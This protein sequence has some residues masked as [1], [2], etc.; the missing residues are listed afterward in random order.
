VTP[1]TPT[2]GTPS[3]LPPTVPTGGSSPG[4]SP[5][6]TNPTDGTGTILSPTFIV[7][8]FG[9]GGS[10]P[11]DA[12]WDAN[13]AVCF[14]IASSSNLFAGGPAFS[15]NALSLDVDTDLRVRSKNG[16]MVTP[17]LDKY[18]KFVRLYTLGCFDEARTELNSITV[19]RRLATE[20]L[21]QATMNNWYEDSSTCIG[22]DPKTCDYKNA[23]IVYYQNNGN[24]P[25]DESGIKERVREALSVIAQELESHPDVDDVA[26]DT[27][28]VAKAVSQNSD[29]GTDSNAGTIVGATAAGLALLLFL[30]LW[31]KRNKDSDEVSHLKF[32][33]DDETFVNEFEGKNGGLESDSDAEGRRVHV[34]G[35]SD[36]VMSGWTGYS[37]DEDSICSDADRSGKLG[38]TMGD[39][40]ICSSATC[41]ICERRRQMGVMFVKTS[42]PPMP[43]RPPSVPSNATR[44]YVAEDVVAL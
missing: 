37:V 20:P 15:F 31:A 4:E 41:E 42:A 8:D 39:V 1:T 13:T 44:E 12:D 2:G 22:S 35:E 10:T 27:T 6:A 21:F 17:L 18:T 40:H 3:I 25:P 7:P 9:S 11:Q 34:I 29:A 38:H 43:E 28:G 19:R 32:V 16:L 33:E 30:L 14:S 26:V 5:T 36:S 24:T 23:I